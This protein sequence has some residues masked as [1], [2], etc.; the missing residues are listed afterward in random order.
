MNNKRGYLQISFGWLFAIIVGA[1]IL[2]LAIFISYKMIK[3]ERTQQDVQL[4]KELDVLLNP[5]ETSVETST[6]TSIVTPLETRIFLNCSL[7][8]TYPFGVQKTIVN[9]KSMNKWSNTN[10]EVPSY[11]RY[12]FL[13]EPSEGKRFYLFSRPFKVPFKVADVTYLTSSQDKYCFINPP[14]NIAREIDNLNQENLL[15]KNSEKDECEKIS[16]EDRIDVC[17]N[18]G[19][20]DINVNYEQGKVRKKGDTLEFSSDSLMYAAI[21]SNKELYEC[22]VKR[23]M[24]KTIILIDLYLKKIDFVSYKGCDASNLKSNLNDLKIM[25][26]KV[27]QGNMNFLHSISQIS[28]ELK[29][30]QE[31]ALCRIW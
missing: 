4:G 26:N 12:V 25:S 24:R 1:F 5:L 20:C 10:I 16:E 13:K 8:E 21:F 22:Q 2:F 3:T 11:N 7:G 19:S 9:Q 29:N 28:K 31:N 23:L 18:R 15:L 17:F 30:K 27:E 6:S 14:K